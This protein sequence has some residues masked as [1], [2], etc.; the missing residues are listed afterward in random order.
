VPTPLTRDEALRMLGVPAHADATTVKRAYRRLVRHHHPDRGGDP[1]TFHDLQRAYE[2]LAAPV[3]PTAPAVSQGRP[4]RPYARDHAEVQQA[5]VEAVDWAASPGAV[6]SPLTTDSV[7]VWLAS[8]DPLR[9]LEATSRAPGSRLNRVAATLAPELTSRLRIA[10]K[11]DDRG[12]AVVTI[13]LIASNR[14][15][16][17]ALDAVS[18]D[19]VWI[20]TRRSSSTVLRSTL[21]LSE[22]PRVTA[23]R[24][25]VRLVEVLDRLRWPLRGW[26]ATTSEQ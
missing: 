6:G 20:R 8:D 17:R 14:R 15:A 2:H 22:D 25:T 1:A 11:I 18:L 16:R 4:S 26:I 21:V 9:P 10:S 5:D 23:V 7:A 3:T 13:E 24:V 19:G 12:A